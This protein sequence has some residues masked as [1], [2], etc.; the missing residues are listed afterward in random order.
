MIGEY[1]CRRHGQRSVKTKYINISCYL[2]V[3]DLSFEIS[4]LHLFDRFSLQTTV[5]HGRMEV[6]RIVG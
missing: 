5:L 4:R 2:N 1:T 6:L 3:W